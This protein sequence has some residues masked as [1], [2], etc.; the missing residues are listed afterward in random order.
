M[1]P[2]NKELVTLKSKCKQY[3]ITLIKTLN[4]PDELLTI[5]EITKRE[6]LYRLNVRKMNRKDTAKSLGYSI[7]WF[8]TKCKSLGILPAYRY[9]IINGDK[10][11]VMNKGVQG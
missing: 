7:G 11:R 10:V 6:I 3:E 2:R 1:N 5:D 8:A 4:D 9:E